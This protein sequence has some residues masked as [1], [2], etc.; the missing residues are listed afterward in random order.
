MRR[1][2]ILHLHFFLCEKCLCAQVSGCK[3]DCASVWTHK[4]LLFRVIFYYF[5]NIFGF[6]L[7]YISM[8]ILKKGAIYTLHWNC[9]IKVTMMCFFHSSPDDFFFKFVS[10]I[11]DYY[12]ASRCKMGCRL[13]LGFW[14]LK[15][16]SLDHGQLYQKNSYWGV[17]HLFQSFSVGRLDISWHSVFL[18][19]PKHFFLNVIF[20]YFFQRQASW[21]SFD[22]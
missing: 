13:P 6:C 19:Y 11:F 9:A 8:D 2:K 21:F 5:I 18:T 17:K 15:V 3:K 20:Y 10:K 16:F 14:R 4:P 7:L 12:F 22:I 1:K